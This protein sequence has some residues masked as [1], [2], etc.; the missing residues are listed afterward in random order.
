MSVED[1]MSVVGFVCQYSVFD[2]AKML[3]QCKGLSV[4]EAIQE[5]QNK[6]GILPL[7]IVERIRGEALKW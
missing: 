3:I 5:L 2:T 1:K 6:L 4:D 7:E